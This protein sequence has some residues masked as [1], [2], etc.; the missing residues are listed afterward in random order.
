[1]DGLTRSYGAQELRIYRMKP[2]LGPPDLEHLRFSESDVSWEREWEHF[3]GA[4]RS[5]DGRPLL[6]DLESA[7]YAWQC[8]EQAV[9]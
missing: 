7:A 8:V 9:R 5:G 4:V 2:E 6:G 1:M 3:A